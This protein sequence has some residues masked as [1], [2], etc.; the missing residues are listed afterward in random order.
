[1]KFKTKSGIEIDAVQFA[2]S[3]IPTGASF[4]IGDESFPVISD[5][6]GMPIIEIVS[7]IGGKVVVNQGDWIISIGLLSHERCSPALFGFLFESDDYEAQ[8][9]AL[10]VAVKK[11]TQD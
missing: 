4:Q 11:P 5:D 2:L 10:G 6:N 1:M 8:K 9:A 7:E 3:G